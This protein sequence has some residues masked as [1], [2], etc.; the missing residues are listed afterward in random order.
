MQLLYLAITYARVVASG[1][2]G[3]QPDREWSK[4]SKKRSRNFT[5]KSNY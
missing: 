1:V 4:T 5:S 3:E 2:C